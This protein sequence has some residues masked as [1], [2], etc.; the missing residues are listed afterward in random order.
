MPAMDVV[1]ESM[2]KTHVSRIL[3]NLGLR[4]TAQAVI[5][6]CETGLAY[7]R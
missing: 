2:V 5:L 6:A 3:V 7:P 4:D 1:E